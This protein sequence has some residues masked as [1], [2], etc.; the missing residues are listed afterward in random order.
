LPPQ[1]ARRKILHHRLIVYQQG[2]LGACRQTFVRHG[3]FQDGDLPDA[4]QI[5]FE[6]GNPG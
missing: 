3:L 2:R 4:R 6:G 1:H 5:D